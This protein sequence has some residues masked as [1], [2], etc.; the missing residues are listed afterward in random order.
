MDIGVKT[1]CVCGASSFSEY[2]SVLWPALVS[3]WQLSSEEERYINIQQGVQCTTCSTNVRSIALAQALLNFV[4]DK[5][6]LISSITGGALKEAKILEI[7]EAGLLNKFFKHIPGHRL[8]QY[9]E[10]DMMNLNIADSSY[11]I[12]VHSDTLEHVEFP[13]RGLSECRRVLRSGGA[14]CFTVPVITDRMTRSRRGLPPSHHGSPRR[15]ED[16][17]V[18]FEFGADFWTYPIRA[19]FEATD[20]HTL[21][22]PSGIAIVAK[23]LQ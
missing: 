6:T 21:A 17:L 15:P 9:P 19:G 7:N 10:Y 18:H 22:Y 3:E 20:I 1:C 5:G 23:R 14:C 16:N 12:V 2:R 8:I 11:D 13:I 4:G